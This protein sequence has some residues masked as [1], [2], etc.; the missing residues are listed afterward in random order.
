MPLIRLSGLNI[1][2][3]STSGKHLARLVLDPQLINVTGKYFSGLH[4]IPSSQASYDPE[5]ARELWEGSSELV[6]L[7]SDETLLHV[8]HTLS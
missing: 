3:V 6:K 2:T 7:A 1:N 4:E 5:K 8:H